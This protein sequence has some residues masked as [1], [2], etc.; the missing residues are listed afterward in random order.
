M[1]LFSILRLGKLVSSEEN[2][3]S[4]ENFRNDANSLENLE[5]T[6]HNA[7]PQELCNATRSQIFWWNQQEP[8]EFACSPSLNAKYAGIQ[9]TC[10]EMFRSF[11]NALRV[12]EDEPSASHFILRYFGFILD[13]PFINDDVV[14]LDTMQVFLERLFEVCQRYFGLFESSLAE[15]KSTTIDSKHMM[16]AGG[17][18][19]EI[20]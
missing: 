12:Y 16:Q 6:R 18:F 13:A 15:M 3:T 17:K 7:Q 14:Q 9:E 11:L 10:V 8:P 5:H 1:T 20:F 4:M 2:G 19:Y